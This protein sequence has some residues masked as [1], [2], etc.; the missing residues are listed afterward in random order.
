VFDSNTTPKY[1][2][3]LESELERVLIN[4]KTEMVSTEDYKKTLSLV[5][6]LHAL[7]DKEKP[8]AVSKDAMLNVAAN[9]VGIILIIRHENVNVIASKALQFVVRTKV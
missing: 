4:L 1:Q 3:M 7:M 9:L 2:R 5:E 6:K 8:R